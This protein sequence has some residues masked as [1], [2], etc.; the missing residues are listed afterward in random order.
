MQWIL[1][2]LELRSIP[3]VFHRRGRQIKSF[4]G[5]WRSALKS[6][7]ISNKVPHDLRRTAVRNLI[8]AGVPERVAMK[9]TGHKT[10]SIFDRYNIVNERDLS[11]GI[12]KLAIYY[13][14]KSVS[15]PERAEAV[16]EEKKVS[17]G[18]SGKVISFP[19]HNQNGKY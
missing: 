7:G 14:Q 1:Q 12:E 3:W 15:P 2:L 16:T 13:G 19:G 5:A 4:K 18:G 17:V 8:R 10:R 11:E 9:I 6:S